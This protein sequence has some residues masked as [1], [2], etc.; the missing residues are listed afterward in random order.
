MFKGQKD[1]LHRMTDPSPTL[2]AVYWLELGLTV[3][4]R[5]TCDALERSRSSW[6][7][8]EVGGV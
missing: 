8:S 3:A 4:Q 6:W 5:A 2:A 7:E 1:V